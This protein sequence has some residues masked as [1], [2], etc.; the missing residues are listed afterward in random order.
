MTH[1]SW[2]GSA[3]LLLLALHTYGFSRFARSQG[4]LLEGRRP[5]VQGY[6]RWSR[7]TRNAT[8]QVGYRSQD[9]LPAR[10]FFIFANTCEQN[11]SATTR[12]TVR[13]LSGRNVS[14][15]TPCFSMSRCGM[16]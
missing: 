14:R 12:F 15:D 11:A 7:S 5:Y 13:I 2:G 4:V 3:P 6:C 1:R 16:S 9:R 8:R 10:A